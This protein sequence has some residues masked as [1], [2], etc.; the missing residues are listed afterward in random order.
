MEPYFRLSEFEKEKDRT[1]IRVAVVMW[2]RT[3]TSKN[4]KAKDVITMQMFGK[5]LHH[6][7]LTC[8][9][10]D[11]KAIWGLVSRGGEHTCVTIRRIQEL[12]DKA[13]VARSAQRK[14]KKGMV[15]FRSDMRKLNSARDAIDMADLALRQAMQSGAVVNAIES[16]RTNGVDA[17]EFERKVSDVLL[18]SVTVLVADF[19]HQLEVEEILNSDIVKAAY[20]T[21]AV[22]EGASS[23]SEAAPTVSSTDRAT[24]VARLSVVGA[25][26]SGSAADVAA[27]AVREVE[28][29]RME[30]GPLPTLTA[31][32]QIV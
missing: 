4:V 20:G 26:G 7:G 32:T 12:V 14:L 17:R 21:A 30:A 1:I 23:G 2:E 27:R 10:S 8:V 15:A 3:H 24:R 25:E 5:A 28:M 13:L 19:E 16:A 9:G 22:G 11:L 6:W 18:R 31:L 29:G